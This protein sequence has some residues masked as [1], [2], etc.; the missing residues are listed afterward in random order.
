M[1]SSKYNKQ[2]NQVIAL[3]ESKPDYVMRDHTRA[4]SFKRIEIVCCWPPSKRRENNNKNQIVGIHLRISGHHK[5]ALAQYA[6]LNFCANWMK[7]NSMKRTVDLISDCAIIVATAGERR[8]IWRAYFSVSGFFLFVF[9]FAIAIANIQCILI[10]KWRWA[11]TFSHRARTHWD[12]KHARAM[13]TFRSFTFHTERWKVGALIY[14]NHVL[15][16]ARL[17]CAHSISAAQWPPD[18]NNDQCHTH[19]HTHLCACSLVSQSFQH[20]MQLPGCCC[21]CWVSNRAYNQVWLCALKRA[22][23]YVASEAHALTLALTCLL[24]NYYS[25]WLGMKRKKQTARERLIII[26]K[27]RQRASERASKKKRLRP[28]IVSFSSRNLLFFLSFN[29]RQIFPLHLA[30]VCTHNFVYIRELTWS[31]GNAN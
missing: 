1:L 26:H 6:Q 9:V 30:C 12:C 13:K 17:T 21:C 11:M 14:A 3:F 22:R 2:V 8:D 4:H 16:L 28:L 24:L 5:M 10:R 7:W 19:T 18:T 27:S 31:P 23:L 25:I 20:L 15:I 29:L